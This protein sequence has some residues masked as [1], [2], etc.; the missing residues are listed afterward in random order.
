[1]QVGARSDAFAW[2]RCNVATVVPLLALAPA[3]AL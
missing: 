2:L 1:M 3:L